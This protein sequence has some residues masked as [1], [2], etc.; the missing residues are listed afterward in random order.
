[1][2][3]EERGPTARC[4]SVL[5]AVQKSAAGSECRRSQPGRSV[6]DH[7]LSF[8]TW[9]HCQTFASRGPENASLRV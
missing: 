1:V 8:G 4:V 2:V 9:F 3:A 7:A 5:R 6:S